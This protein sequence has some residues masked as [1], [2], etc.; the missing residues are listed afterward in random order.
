[1]QVAS[2]DEK[3]GF[4][5]PGKSFADEKQYYDAVTGSNPEY[6]LPEYPTA[7]LLA[8][9]IQLEFSGLDFSTSSYFMSQ[10]SHSESSGGFL[11]FHFHHSETKSRQVSHVQTSK[12]ASGLK[13]KVPGAQLIGYY[14]ETLPKFPNN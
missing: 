9:N 8:R 6:I 7:F 14:T 2:N 5:S 12:T 13:I 3:V 10:Y 11:F 1:M 4:V